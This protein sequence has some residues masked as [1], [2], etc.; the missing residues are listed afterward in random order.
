MDAQIHSKSDHPEESGGKRV[1]VITSDFS[2]KVKNGMVMIEASQEENVT[3]GLRGGVPRTVTRD[4]RLLFGRKDML[5]IFEA[6]VGSSLK[7]SKKGH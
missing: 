6:I 5:R 7:Y 2:I 4:L 1:R 3:T